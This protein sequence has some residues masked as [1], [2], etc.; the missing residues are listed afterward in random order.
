MGA[1]GPIGPTGSA[2]VTGPTGP[3]GP[4]GGAFTYT[5]T[6]LL[7]SPCGAIAYLPL[8]G[9]SHTFTVPAGETHKV[10]INAFGTCSKASNAQDRVF[11]QYDVFVNGVAQNA[12]QRVAIDD[13]TPITGYDECP[14][15]ISKVFTLGPGLYTIDIRGTSAT[16]CAT[17]AVWLCTA[18]GQVGQATMNVFVMRY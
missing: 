9:V 2:G 11:A 5:S 14:W 12:F 7:T 18:T 4:S 6:A 13:E 16:G 1:A 10:L 8:P 15:G 3:N 17:P